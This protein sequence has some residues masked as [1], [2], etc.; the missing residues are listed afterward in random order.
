[1]ELS[2]VTLLVLREV[3]YIVHNLRASGFDDVQCYMCKKFAGT[4]EYLKHHTCQCILQNPINAA[5]FLTKDRMY[6]CMTEGDY[7]A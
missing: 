3:L 5:S 6:V 1:M 7:R 2:A 4:H